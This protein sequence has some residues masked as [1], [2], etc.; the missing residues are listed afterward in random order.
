MTVYTAKELQKL[1]KDLGRSD[2]AE[3]IG[4]ACTAKGLAWLDSGMDSDED[5]SDEQF[6]RL[7]SSGDTEAKNAYAKKKFGISL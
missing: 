2:E 3:R 7:M 6:A 5:L 4:R 1:L